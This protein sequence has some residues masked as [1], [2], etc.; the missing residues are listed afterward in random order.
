MSDSSPPPTP[1]RQSPRLSLPAIPVGAAPVSPRPGSSRRSE[2]QKSPRINSRK[3][4]STHAERYSNWNVVVF[5]ATGNVGRGAVFAHLKEG[6]KFVFAVSRRSQKIRALHE[7]YLMSDPRVI[8]IIANVSTIEGAQSAFEQIIGVVSEI[9]HVVC[10]VGGW[11]REP[12]SSMDGNAFMAALSS[13][14]CSHFYVW[15]A[16]NNVSNLQT[17][18][19]LNGAVKDHIPMSGVTGLCAKQLSAL[20]QCLIPEN[21]KIQLI[22]LVVGGRVADNDDDGSVVYPTRVFGQIFVEIANGRMRPES[23]VIS[24]RIKEK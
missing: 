16:F 22:E 15:K 5:G 20:I 4:I 2:S 10:C 21:Q 6:A 18:V 9:H 19:I 12:L 24:A 8:P 13:N 3:C 23:G 17:F 11:I 1:P 7:D 14:V